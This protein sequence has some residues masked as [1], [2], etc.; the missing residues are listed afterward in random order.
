MSHSGE[1]SAERYFE[2]STPLGVTVITTKEYWTYLVNVKHVMMN[3]KEDIVKQ[4][5][6]DPEEVRK[7]KIDGAVFLDDKT[8]G[9]MFCVVAKHEN[10]SGFLITAH[11]VD[12]IKEGEV[13]WTK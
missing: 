7:S 11:P 8:I 1:P 5:L 10:T 13:V 12:T 6:V 2:V 4:T 9:R 3:G